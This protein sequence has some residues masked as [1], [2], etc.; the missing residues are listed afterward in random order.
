MNPSCTTATTEAAKGEAGLT[1]DGGGRGR[2]NGE[3][4]N[5][6]AV[7]SSPQVCIVGGGLPQGTPARAPGRDPDG[8]E[9]ARGDHFQQPGGQFLA[10]GRDSFEGALVPDSCLSLDS[11]LPFGGF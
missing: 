11:A 4:P 3:E 1:G 8:E 9:V 6:E 10:H 5:T 2:S 7:R